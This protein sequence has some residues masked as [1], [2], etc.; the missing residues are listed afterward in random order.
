MK[1]NNSD[2]ELNF[3]ENNLKKHYGYDDESLL[4]VWEEAMQEWEQYKAANPEAAAQSEKEADISFD[5]LMK[6]AAAEHA[7]PAGERVERYVREEGEN[8]EEICIDELLEKTKGGDVPLAAESEVMR[9]VKGIK[10]NGDPEGS[11]EP[12]DPEAK[13][14][15]DIESPKASTVKTAFNAEL[16]PTD[17]AERTLIETTVTD[18]QERQ[19][20]GAV[21]TEIFTTEKEQTA[22]TTLMNEHAGIDSGNFTDSKEAVSVDKIKSIRRNKRR[23]RVVILAA[24]VAVMVIGGGI[25]ATA[26]TRREYKVV[27]LNGEKTRIIQHNTIV[28]VKNGNLEK[29]YE[30]IKDE[31]DIPVVGLGYMPSG[32]YLCKDVISKRNAVLEFE[33][34]EKKVYLKESKYPLEDASDM[35][36][37]DR[38]ACQEVVNGWLNKNLVID[39]NELE[40]GMIEYSTGFYDNEVYYYLSGIIDKNIFVEIAENLCLQ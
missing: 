7:K 2:A 21:E 39:R 33:Y 22:S 32:M 3:I 20:G 16:I 38:T 15:T 40:D 24:A 17:P 36:V 18:I 31:L 14:K 4:R 10:E 12:E 5:L 13:S 29:A 26:T 9:E 37:S 8:E 28:T 1:K 30:R 6:Q 19:E 35:I 27:I 23:R 34:N 11:G 25:V